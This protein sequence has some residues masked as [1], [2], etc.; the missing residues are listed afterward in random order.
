ML[1]LTRKRGQALRVGESV[2]VTVVRCQGG[3]VR[4]DLEHVEGQD[5]QDQYSTQTIEQRKA[6]VPR[7][8]RQRRRRRQLVRRAGRERRRSVARA[9]DRDG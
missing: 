9:R 1:V 8:R 3:R 4:R 7:R 5:P 2:V 6:W